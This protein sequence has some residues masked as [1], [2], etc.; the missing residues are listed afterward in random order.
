MCLPSV[1]M[2]PFVP[3]SPAAATLLFLTGA[4]VTGGCDYVCRHL[5]RDRE[6]TGARSNLGGN[7]MSITVEL[8]GTRCA[9]SR[10]NGQTVVVAALAGRG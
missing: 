2:L 1:R 10:V 6:R 5:A 7:G 4:P 9:C 3:S 8:S